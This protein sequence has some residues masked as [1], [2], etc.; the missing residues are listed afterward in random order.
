MPD[1]VVDAA[2]D[3]E[4]TP[5]EANASPQDAPESQPAHDPSDATPTAEDGASADGTPEE[6]SWLDD[7]DP[8]AVLSHPRIKTKVDGLVGDLAQKRA[9]AE[10]AR[11]RADLEAEIRAEVTAEN[12]RRQAEEAEAERL[13][14]L[15]KAADEDDLLTLAEHSKSEVQKRREREQAAQEATRNLQVVS[16]LFSTTAS[17]TLSQFLTTLP[18]DVQARLTQA[19]KTYGEGKDWGAGFREYLADI[20][21]TH[22]AHAVEQARADLEAEL[23]PAIEKELLAKLN[24]TSSAEIGT[25]SAPAGALTQQEW[26]RQ[27]RDPAWRRANKARIDAALEAGRIHN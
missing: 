10:A 15:E 19:N 3:T 4:G 23:R 20:V 12:E 24:A 11:I 16:E 7:A 22:A 17:E 9:K 27:R 26:E 14:R 5:P 2:P 8:D 18:A 21:E 13:R 6:R 25:G 1:P